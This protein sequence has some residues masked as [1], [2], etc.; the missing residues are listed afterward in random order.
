MELK[1]NLRNWILP[2]VESCQPYCIRTS[3][4]IRIPQSNHA[5]VTAV[6]SSHQHSKLVSFS[7]WIYK[8]YNLQSQEISSQKKLLNMS[9]TSVSMAMITQSFQ[10]FDKETIDTHKTKAFKTSTVVELEGVSYYYFLKS[11]VLESTIIFVISWNDWSPMNI[12]QGLNIKNAESFLIQRLG[13]PCTGSAEHKTWMM[14]LPLD[15]QAF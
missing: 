7:P 1:I 10:I 14:E 6:Q 3:T 11:N 15:S 8:V 12:L 4:M 2:C 9:T 13:H 5:K